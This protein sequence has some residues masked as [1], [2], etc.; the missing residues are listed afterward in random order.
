MLLKGLCHLKT[1]LNNSTEIDFH[2][3]IE[4]LAGYFFLPEIHTQ[5]ILKAK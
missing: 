5:N 3:C 4:G 2:T 1:S